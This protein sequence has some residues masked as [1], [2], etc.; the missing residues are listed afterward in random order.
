M[1]PE[2]YRLA[3]VAPAARASLRRAGGHLYD[4][5]AADVWSAGCVA[6]ELLYGAP[7]FSRDAKG[8]SAALEADILSAEPVPLPCCTRAGALVS[9]LAREFLQARTAEERR[10]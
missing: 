9:E 6:W 2:I 10:A 7:L 3:K 1:A 4:G 8:G 5:P